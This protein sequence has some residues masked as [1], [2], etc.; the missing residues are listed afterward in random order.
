MSVK[1]VVLTVTFLMLFSVWAAIATGAADSGLGEEPPVSNRSAAA[2]TALPPGARIS[3]RI[4]GLKGL[5]NVGW[6]AAGIFRGAQPRPDGHA[7]LKQMGIRTVVNLRTK[8]SDKDAVK[9]AGMKSVEIPLD[10]MHNP[11]TDTIDRIVDTIIDPAN[12]PVYVHCRLGQDRTGVVVAVYRMRV[13]GWSLPEA[14][15]E[16][17]AFGF[18]D[19]WYNLKRFVRHY[20]GKTQ[21][22]R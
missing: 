1:P 9:A 14:E 17:Q 3:Q 15:A 4:F 8:H 2:D 16:M 22:A 7:T 10:C 6:V 18:N 20:P 19:I 11:K 21:K 12:Q 5:S 13:E